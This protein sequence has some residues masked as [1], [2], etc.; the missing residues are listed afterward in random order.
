MSE[1]LEFRIFEG[2]NL[3]E[4]LKN[5]F[6]YQFIIR[7]AKYRIWKFIKIFFTCAICN[8]TFLWHVSKNWFYSI[9]VPTV[10]KPI[11]TWK[12][13]ISRKK[14]TVLAYQHQLIYVNFSQ[15][16]RFEYVVYNA[17]TLGRQKYHF[18]YF[19]AICLLSTLFL[20][21]IDLYNHCSSMYCIVLLPERISWLVL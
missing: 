15:Y 18:G 10:L 13:C 3:H 16:S 6:F 4:N 2:M 14:R 21:E 1:F 7:V 12:I 8:I 17:L 20:A 11:F 19:C 9:S 5:Q